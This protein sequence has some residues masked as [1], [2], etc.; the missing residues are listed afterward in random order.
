MQQKHINQYNQ[1]ELKDLMSE[2]KR[3]LVM[4]ITSPKK[5]K[6]YYLKLLI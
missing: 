5:L 1:E 6:V 2:T 3:C 4:M